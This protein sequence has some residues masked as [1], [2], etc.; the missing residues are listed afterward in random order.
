MTDRAISILKNSSHFSFFSILLLCS[1]IHISLYASENEYQRPS[2]YQSPF[3]TTSQQT[4]QSQAVSYPHLE[5]PT[6]QPFRSNYQWQP[7][8]GIP[9]QTAAPSQ[10]SL[11][12][13]TPPIPI[14]AGYQMFYTGQPSYYGSAP[15]SSVPPYSATEKTPDSACVGSPSSHQF[16]HRRSRSKSMEE[17]TAAMAAGSTFALAGHAG[18]DA[19]TD[20]EIDTQEKYA[21]FS[22]EKILQMLLEADKKATDN[23]TQLIQGIQQRTITQTQEW[24]NVV[25]KANTQS[26]TSRR[27]SLLDTFQSK[28]KK[29]AKARERELNQHD[30]EIKPAKRSLIAAIGLLDSIGDH[31]ALSLRRVNGKETPTK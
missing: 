13:A 15:Q 11:Y 14:P 18:A 31:A 26:P 12:S 3:E 8:D 17:L 2:T 20:S 19:E 29:A 22:D 24:K 23:L 16:G 1:C 27:A 10:Q 7:G 4:G 6:Q 9:A 28:E 5:T 30:A 21:S 25:K